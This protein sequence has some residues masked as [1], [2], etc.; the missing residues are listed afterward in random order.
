P[1][2]SFFGQLAVIVGDARRPFSRAPLGQVLRL[3]GL[4]PF[5]LALVDVDQL[6]EGLLG[7]RLAVLQ[8]AQQRL[9]SIEQPC[10]EI[11]LGQREKRLMALRL[12]QARTGEQFL[13]HPYRT[14]DLAA[15]AEEMPEREM[16]LE[17][18]VI[19]LRKLDE[20]LERLVGLA[21]QDE[22]QAA[23]I[24]GVDAGRR[25]VVALAAQPIVR[26]A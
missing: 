13:M 15:S 1:K 8:L 6:L 20:E 2:P 18:L 24:V 21:V 26:P 22:V 19:D 5:P 23:E 16:R 4:L 10:A 3:D 12:T 9:R 11:V 25:G 17:R 14:V 7:Q